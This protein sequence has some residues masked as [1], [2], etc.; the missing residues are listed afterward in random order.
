MYDIKP[1]S[2]RKA[3]E[4]NIKIKP[5]NVKGKKIDIY[6][7]DKKI[8]SIGAIGYG[9]Y[10]TFVKE[11]GIEYANERRKLHKIRQE[12]DRHNKWSNG[13]LADKILW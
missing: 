10:P 2:Y 6:K 1:Y 9:D 4:L 5:S 13:W 8:A 3:R 11:K 7:D 12:K